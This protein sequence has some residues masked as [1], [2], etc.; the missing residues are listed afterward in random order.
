[1]GQRPMSQRRETMPIVAKESGAGDRLLRPLCA[2]RLPSTLPEREGWVDR[3]QLLAGHG[4]DPEAFVVLYA[5]IFNPA[6]GLDVLLELKHALLNHH[7][8]IHPWGRPN[9]GSPLLFLLLA[10]VPRPP[11]L[12]F[13]FSLGAAIGL[14]LAVGALSSVVARSAESPP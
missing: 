11:S 8:Q 14:H 5:G 6:Q 12:N 3:E 9:R 2:K 1:M 13:L 4:L 7:L 10:V